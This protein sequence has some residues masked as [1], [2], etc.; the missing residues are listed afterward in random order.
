MYNFLISFTAYHSRFR[1]RMVGHFYRSRFLVSYARDSSTTRV[2]W[3][4]TRGATPPLAFSDFARAGLFHRS[5]FSISY[6]R[7][8]STAR[9]FRFRTR[10]TLLCNTSQNSSPN[11]I[12]LVFAH[13]KTF[14]VHQNKTLAKSRISRFILYPLTILLQFISCQFH[15][16]LNM[17]S[18]GEHVHRL[19]FFYGIAAFI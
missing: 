14:Q 10:G 9:V 1:I 18:L 4:H 12:R 5:R 16:C 3:F 7:D 17:V 6:A 15:D 8:S 13:A 19:G 2:F 11:S